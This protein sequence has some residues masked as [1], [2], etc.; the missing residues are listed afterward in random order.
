MTGRIEARGKEGGEG[1]KATS[2]L[3]TVVLSPP[4]K[5][6]CHVIGF[7]NL[8]C[9]YWKSTRMNCNS[10]F[11]LSNYVVLTLYKHRKL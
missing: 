4:V 2:D 3:N 1:V 8:I 7:E 6:L 5:C 9:V 11:C 10:Y